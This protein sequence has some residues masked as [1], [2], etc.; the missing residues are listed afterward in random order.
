MDRTA[1]IHN[2]MIT[3]VT[4]MTTAEIATVPAEKNIVL[5]MAGHS[6]TV[7]EDFQCRL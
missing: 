4:G 6:I 1:L 3:G 7:T 2:A 5:D